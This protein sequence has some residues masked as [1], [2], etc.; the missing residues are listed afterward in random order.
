MFYLVLSFYK[1]TQKYDKKKE[2]LIID[3]LGCIINRVGD[4]ENEFLSY[5]VLIWSNSIKLDFFSQY[6]IYY[7]YCKYHYTVDT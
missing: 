7:F 3:F 5:S 1:T 2:N 6:R 4:I